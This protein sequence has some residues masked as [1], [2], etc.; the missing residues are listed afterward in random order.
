MTDHRI[1]L[2]DSLTCETDFFYHQCEKETWNKMEGKRDYTCT[3]H[4]PQDKRGNEF[5]TEKLQK[6]K[7]QVFKNSKRLGP[8]LTFD[9]PCLQ[10]IR[11]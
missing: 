3:K 11:N 10:T 4:F 5:K 1:Y 8:L 2:I 9:A 7:W 6:R